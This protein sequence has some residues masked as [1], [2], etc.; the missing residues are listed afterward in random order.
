VEFC[1]PVLI[2]QDS[3]RVA[4][5]V[6]EALTVI[7]LLRLRIILP[8]PF[9]FSSHQ[10]FVGM[11]A[12]LLHF[13][14]FAAMHLFDL[15]PSHTSLRRAQSFHAPLALRAFSFRGGVLVS[16]CLG[17]DRRMSALRVWTV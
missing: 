10:R 12:F 7:V 4:L 15:P 8:V 9:L 16:L 2:A 17:S 14:S 5:H 6:I 3:A 13:R 1:D 11:R